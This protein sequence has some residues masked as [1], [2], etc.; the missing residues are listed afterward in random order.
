MRSRTSLDRSRR[1]QQLL[2]AASLT[3]VAECLFLEAEA[4][5]LRLI[6]RYVLG[7]FGASGRMGFGELMMRWS[8]REVDIV[9]TVEAGDLEVEG[10]AA[11][12]FRHGLVVG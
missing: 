3:T 11:W 7:R 8:G 2:L 10:R 1:H 6:G 4:H 12:S 9:M 5:C